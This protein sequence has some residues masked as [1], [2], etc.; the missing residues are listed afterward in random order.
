MAGAEADAPKLEDAAPKPNA[1]VEAADEGA[2]NPPKGAVAAGETPNDGADDE[3]VP[4][5]GVVE[6]NKESAIVG[7]W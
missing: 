2:P 1:G 7:V 6:P 3:G 5:V 4:K